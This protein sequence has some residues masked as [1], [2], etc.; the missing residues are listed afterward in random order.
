MGFRSCPLLVALGTTLEGGHCKDTDTR[1]QHE[2]PQRSPINLRARR[3]SRELPPPLS[4]CLVASACILASC[5]PVL[6]AAL[7]TSL[8]RRRNLLEPCA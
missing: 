1:K 2:E 7:S 6:Q 4:L 5:A 3:L 8:T